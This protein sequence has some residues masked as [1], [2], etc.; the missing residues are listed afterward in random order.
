MI[1]LHNGMLQNNKNELTMFTTNNRDESHKCKVEQK[2][3]GVKEYI[4]Y[5]AP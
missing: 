3:L 2:K 4:L 5:H 1:Q